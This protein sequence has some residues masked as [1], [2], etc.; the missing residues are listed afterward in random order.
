MNKLWIEFLHISQ[1]CARYSVDAAYY[2]ECLFLLC[3]SLLHAVD[4]R[5]RQDQTDHEEVCSHRAS[6]LRQSLVFRLGGWVGMS[7]CVR[8]EPN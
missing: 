3:R 7:G 2:T 8:E 6:A 5:R 4:T 1:H